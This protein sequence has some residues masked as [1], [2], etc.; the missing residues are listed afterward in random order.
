MKR[1]LPISL[2]LLILSSAPAYAEWA[3]VGSSE[4]GGGVTVY[5]DRDT[6]RRKG[7]L[8]KMCTCPTSRLYKPWRATR[9]C[10]ASC[11]TNTTAQKSVIGCLHTRTSLA[12]W[13]AVRWVTA[14]HPKTSGNQFNQRVLVKL[15]GKWP[16]TSSDRA[17]NAARL[18]V[19][20]VK[21]LISK[22]RTEDSRTH[23]YR[24]RFSARRSYGFRLCNNE[25]SDCHSSSASSPPT[26]C[27]HFMTRLV[28]YKEWPGWPS[29]RSS[30]DH[31]LSSFSLRAG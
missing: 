22:G 8:V 10:L 19:R 12:I 20:H 24:I 15:C 21:R 4:N 28:F 5:A 26:S 1:L 27:I 13:V 6:I 17:V 16:A 31:T 3:A 18:K 7:D 11:K 29:L 9:I 14:T 2:T 23:D 30:R 25:G